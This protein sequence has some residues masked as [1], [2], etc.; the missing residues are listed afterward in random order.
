M[1]RLLRTAVI[2]LLLVAPAVVIPGCSRSKAAP[3][4]DAACAGDA[5]GCARL[6][7][8]GVPVN[9]VDCDWN[10]ALMWAVFYCRKDAVATLLNLGADVNHRGQLG[11]TPLMSTGNPLQ[12]HVLHGTRAERTEVADLLIRHGAG[13]NR[14]SDDGETAL[15]FAALSNNADLVRLLLA[16]GADRNIKSDQGYTALDIAKFPDYAP[17]DE[18]IKLLEA[19][20]H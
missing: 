12:G 20:P 11:F 5:D 6:V 17:N 7:K 18:V 4:I 9:A 16:A 2:I 14:R 19:P 10:T 3:L 13:V 1:F 8:S 15:D